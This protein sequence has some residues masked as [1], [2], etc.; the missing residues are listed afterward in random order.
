MKLVDVHAHLEHKRFEKDLDSVIERFKKA[1]GEFIVESGVNPA[2]N[3]VALEL[4]DKF[5]KV[6]NVF[7]AYIV[8]ILDKFRRHV[9]G[10]FVNEFIRI[11]VILHYLYGLRG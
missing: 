8:M 10:F 6:L 11:F 3:R 4:A 9:I 1:G 5:S 2:T 7:R